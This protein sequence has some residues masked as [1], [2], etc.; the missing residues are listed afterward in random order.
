MCSGRDAMESRRSEFHHG[1]NAVGHPLPGSNGLLIVAY[2][3]EGNLPDYDIRGWEGDSPIGGH[4]VQRTKISRDY[5]YY[6]DALFKQEKEVAK[7]AV[8]RLRGALY[9][10]CDKNNDTWAVWLETWT[11]YFSRSHVLKSPEFVE[12]EVAQVKQRIDAEYT[13]REIARLAQQK[14]E[15]RQPTTWIA[16]GIFVV[17][18]VAGLA[19]WIS[20]H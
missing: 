3:G 6:A 2:T 5:K 18:I 10:L 9:V 8:K 17:A 15:L 13:E 19:H 11:D 7:K 4:S 16:V 14:A 20:G 1:R 12:Q